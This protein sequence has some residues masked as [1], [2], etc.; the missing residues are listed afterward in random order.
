MTLGNRGLGCPRSRGRRRRGRR[1][2]G[3]GARR[4]AAT[5]RRGK[6]GAGDSAAASPNWAALDKLERTGSSPAVEIDGERG[7]GKPATVMRRRKQGS[8]VGGAIPSGMPSSSSR[9]CFRVLGRFYRRTRRRWLAQ[10][11]GTAIRRGGG[12]GDRTDVKQGRA[13]SVVTA[14]AARPRRLYTWRGS[15]HVMRVAVA[16]A[17]GKQEV[18]EQRERRR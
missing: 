15:T 10:R 7:R 4:G 13:V 17:H 9:R 14:R 16:V 3:G 1:S 5:A 6:R 2:N 11:R 8:A 18:A 12:R